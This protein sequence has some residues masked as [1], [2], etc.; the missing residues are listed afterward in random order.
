MTYTDGDGGIVWGLAFEKTLRFGFPLREV[1]QYSKRQ[2]GASIQ[3]AMVG[4]EA[5]GWHHGSDRVL[6]FTIPAIPPL[7]DA[8]PY[9]YGPANGWDSPDGWLDFFSFAWKKNA[10]RVPVLG[11]SLYVAGDDATW[12]E[13]TL[14][15]P[16]RTPPDSGWN[17]H[18]SL[19]LA[20]R[21]GS[22]RD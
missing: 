8:N 21:S 3:R 17:T 15:E 11:L 12:D 22:I 20:I 6:E 1:R 7:D 18:R 5:D 19:R 14:V 2:E 9:G 10:I 16:W 4:G 13:C